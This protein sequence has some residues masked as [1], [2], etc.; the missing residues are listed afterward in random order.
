MNEKEKDKK[1]EESDSQASNANNNDDIKNRTFENIED[2]LNKE[3][4]NFDSIDI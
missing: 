1:K 4:P 3:E 2:D